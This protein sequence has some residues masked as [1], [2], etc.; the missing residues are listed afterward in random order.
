M[1]FGIEGVEQKGV[2][3]ALALSTMRGRKQDTALS[4]WTRDQ[5]RQREVGH[6]GCLGGLDH[7]AE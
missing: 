3:S 5:K 4:M 2:E 6:R 7:G 1:K